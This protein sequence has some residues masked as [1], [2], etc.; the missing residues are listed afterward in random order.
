[1]A[2]LSGKITFIT[3]AAQGIGLASVHAFAAAGARVVATDINAEKLKELEGTANVTTR[4]LNVLDTEAV[5]KAV[6]EIGRIDVLFNCAGVVHNGTILECT[7][8][9]LDFA[10]GVIRGTNS[11]DPRA[12]TSS[13]TLGVTWRFR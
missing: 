4:V 8:E 3:A 13:A 11:A 6:A 5:N 10:L 1:M 7:D 2:D 12:W 9:D